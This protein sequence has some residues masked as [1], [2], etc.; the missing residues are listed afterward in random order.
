M[1]QHEK[2]LAMDP[3]LVI[4]NLGI[5]DL[6]DWGQF[7]S[8]FVADYRALLRDYRSLPSEPRIIIWHR[9]AP[10]FPG[11]PLYGDPIVEELNAAI[12]EV[13]RLEDLE[14]IDMEEP[15]RDHADWFPDKLHPNENGTEAIAKVTAAYLKKNR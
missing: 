13:A 7:G 5:N 1:P 4:S 15:L 6:M 12:G 9:L 11:R 3:H 8:D 2:A 14:V 10:L